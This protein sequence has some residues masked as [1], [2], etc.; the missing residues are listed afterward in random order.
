[1]DSNLLFKLKTNLTSGRYLLFGEIDRV[2]I[3][4]NK[5]IIIIY[6]NNNNTHIK[7]TNLLYLM[8]YPQVLYR[9]ILLS[10]VSLYTMSLYLNRLACS[11]TRLVLYKLQLLCT[12]QFIYKRTIQT[13]RL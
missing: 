3:K 10:R 13:L 8:K 2:E 4:T 12:L 5:Y 7:L 9:F 1:M 11:A 6:N